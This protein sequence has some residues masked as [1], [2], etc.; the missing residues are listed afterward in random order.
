LNVLEGPLQGLLIIEPTLFH[1]DRGLFL[2][3]WN[4]RQYLRANNKLDF[5]QDNVSIS[6]KGVLRGLHFQNPAQQGKL[7]TV[8]MGEVFDVV[9]DLRIASKTFSRWYDETL[10]ATNMRQLYIPPGFAHGFAVL[11][12]RALFHYKCTEYYEPSTERTL[13]WND[14]DVGIDWPLDNPILSS[15][16]RVGKRLKDFK[17]EELFAS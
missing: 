17:S 9:V 7:V 16:D 11:S 8:L 6:K 13:L 10:S 4:A 2:E 14:P 3:S 5:V 1:D 15:K 12:H